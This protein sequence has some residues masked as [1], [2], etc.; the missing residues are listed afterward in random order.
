MNKRAVVLAGGLGSRLRPYTI[1]LPK[2]LMPIGEHTILELIIRQLIS[3]GYDHVTLAVNHQYE[4]IKAYFGDGSRWGIAVDYSLE[5][6]PLGTMGP[7]KNIR[8]LPR[9][10]LVMN[11]DILTD[12]NYSHLF[13]KH[14]NDNCLFSVSSYEREN[15][16]DYGVLQVNEKSRLVGFSEKPTSIF[17]VSMGIYM[18]NRDVL[19]YI[20]EDT[21][22][23][24][25][26]L[27]STL[28]SERR[29][30]N[31][32]K[33]GGYWLDIG[34]PDDYEKAIDEYNQNQTQFLAG[35]I[36]D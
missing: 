2:P 27:M 26:N 13:K 29:E 3:F 32:I 6:K 14:V 30:I 12:L 1:L 9:D 34:R 19:R 35:I 24:F 28:L 22:F 36:D 23:G 10:F 16:I 11:G 18:V 21:Y 20:P 5:E 17:E 7:L 31:V 15:V 33:H 4:L 25:D 8:D